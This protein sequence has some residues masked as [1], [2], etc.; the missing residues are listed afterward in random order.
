MRKLITLFAVAASL[1]VAAPAADAAAGRPYQGKT[2]GGHEVT[3]THARGMMDAFVTAVPMTCLSIQGGGA[4]VSGAELWKFDRVRIGLRNFTFSEVSQ[5][6][7][8]YSPVTRTHT[9]TTRRSRTGTI[10]GAIRVQYSF[11]IPKYPPGTFVIYSCL[12]TTKFKAR[13]AG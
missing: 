2:T 3:F 13:P 11:L 5:P 8:H 10:S 1:A 9:V 12:G 4:P 6:S 7:L